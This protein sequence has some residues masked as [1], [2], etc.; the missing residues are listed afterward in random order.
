MRLNF[1]KKNYI[2]LILFIGIFLGLVLFV[3]FPL[4]KN[5]KE[6]SQQLLLEEEARLTFSKEIE[7]FQNFKEAYQ[8][9]EPDL[10]E[11]ES[12]FIIPE[13]PIEFINFLEKTAADSN[14]LLEISSVSP[15]KSEGKTWPSLD[16]NLQASG[17]FSNFSRFVERLENS[18]YLI[19]IYDLN[20]RK[21]SGASDES[22]TENV[23]VN[24]SLKV[25]TK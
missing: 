3:V 6:S 1:G 15:E 8:A 20:M 23:S 14:I 21:S 7:N 25:F 2:S 12:S 10:K 13:P 22:S 18:L 17:S 9:V 19:E 5:I 11:V 4:V 16:F 24:F